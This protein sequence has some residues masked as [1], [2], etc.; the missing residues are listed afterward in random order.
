MKNNY[1]IIYQSN[2]FDGHIKFRNDKLI[3]TKKNKKLHGIGVE[4]IKHIVTSV[5]GIALVKVEKE[6][7][8]FKFLIKMPL[9]P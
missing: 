7:K 5:N 4:S 3:T 9:K 6:K 2:S 1:L 8:E